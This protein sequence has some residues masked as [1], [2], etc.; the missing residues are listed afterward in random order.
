MEQ[1]TRQSPSRLNL[2]S[3]IVGFRLAELRQ[4]RSY[5]AVIVLLVAAIFFSQD[6]YIDVMVEGKGLAH[7]L[8]EGGIFIAVLLALGLEVKHVVELYSS[9][10]I[11]QSEILRMK[12]HLTQVI[13]DEFECWRLTPTEKEI[14]LLL[15]KGLSMQE[16]ADIRH[17]KEKSVRQQATGIYTK[18]GVANRHELSAYFIEDLLEPVAP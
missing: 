1:P 7:I 12:R 9:V 3:H 6:I 17:V 15:I 5:L 14:A 10:S 2:S 18:A 16:I 11:N 8:L 4:S 13:S